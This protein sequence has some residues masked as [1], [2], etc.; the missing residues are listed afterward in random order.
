MKMVDVTIYTTESCGFCK[1]TKEFL[2][3]KGIDY[4]EI[5]VGKDPSKAKEMIE[6]SG[7]TGVPVLV[8]GKEVIV[9]FDQDSIEDAL[10]AG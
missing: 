10:K 2:S 1:A 5:D 6:K 4:K 3:S 7:Q 9:G 8:I